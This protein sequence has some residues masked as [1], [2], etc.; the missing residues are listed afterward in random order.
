MHFTLRAPSDPAVRRRVEQTLR[1]LLPQPQSEEAV[2]VTAGSPAAITGR[3]TD[4]VLALRTTTH[5]CI[6]RGETGL[7]TSLV[8]LRGR[9]SADHLYGPLL[10]HCALALVQTSTHLTLTD[11][12]ADCALDEDM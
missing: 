10:A 2:V 9:E 8:D 3:T 12:P 4:E 5:D 6:L 11:N 7:I 1:P